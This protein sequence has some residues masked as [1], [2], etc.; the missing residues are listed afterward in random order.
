MV[1]TF[2][3][4]WLLILVAHLHL[5]RKWP[6]IMK[7]WITLEIEMRRIYKYPSTLDSTFKR[8]AAFFM[9]VVTGT[10]KHFV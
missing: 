9:V 2:P 10:E 8:L 5:A 6:Q 4:N 7:E 1:F 3:L